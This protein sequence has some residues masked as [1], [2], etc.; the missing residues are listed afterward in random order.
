LIDYFLQNRSI[1]AAAGLAAISSLLLV[2]TPFGPILRGQQKPSVLEFPVNL[3]TDRNTD[4][5]DI[6]AA[7]N[8]TQTQPLY[9]SDWS[10]DGDGY[11]EPGEFVTVRFFLTNHTG[12]TAMN[13]RVALAGG[14]SV[15]YG[16]LPPGRTRSGEVPLTVPAAAACASHLPLTFNVT[17]SLGSMQFVG[18]IL[19]GKPHTTRT[20]ENFDAAAA[21]PAGWNA[22]A[23]GTS[24]SVASTQADSGMNAVMV[25]NSGNAAAASADLTSPQIAV[26]APSGSSAFS[27]RNCFATGSPIAGGVLEISIAEGEFRDFLSAGGTF[28]EN[29]YNSVLASAPGSPLAGRNAWSGDSGGYR[30][31]T[32]RLPTAAAGRLVRLRF[33]FAAASSAPA[34]WRIDTVTLTNASIVTSFSC[35]LLSDLRSKA[36]FDSD[37]KT[38]LA[39][40]RKSDRTFWIN[41]SSRGN[42][43]VQ[44]G[45]DGSI[46]VVADYD[47]DRTTDIAIWNPYDATWLWVS[48]RTGVMQA[49]ELGRYGDIPQP[50]DIDGDGRADFALFRPADGTWSYYLSGEGRF[51]Y[52]QF[53]QYGDVPTIGDYDGDGKADLSVYRPSGGLWYRI[54]S[55]NGQEAAT[56]FGIPTDIPVN[57]DFDGDNK[58]DIAVFRPGSGTWYYESSLT[59]ATVGS[60]WG[61]DGDT[62]L[63][64]DFDGDGKADVAVFRQGEWFVDHLNNT[65]DRYDWGL[66][67]DTPVTQKPYP[68]Y[69][70]AN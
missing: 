66:P 14:G 52:I 13:V 31:T 23:S 42:L 37:G 55:S 67:S 46:P 39:I 54:N 19:L 43:V 61:G 47:G 12:L 24:F 58:E 59:G 44:I 22:T 21:L 62:P 69:V 33:R 2:L 17:S 34:S 18:T 16:N 68:F 4:K 70:P 6:I 41:R 9:V 35:S 28:Q 27:F 64:G 57:A 11:P 38:D 60:V 5:V 50:A 40:F 65:F 3:R 48:S 53:G 1:R 29:G 20:S 32:A 7:S 26:F 49:F 63:A 45:G 10:G 56:Y 15:S 25:E 8:L 51:G 36:D 30:T